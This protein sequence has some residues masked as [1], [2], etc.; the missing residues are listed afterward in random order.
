MSDTK[1][2]LQKI[3]ALR[4]R[5]GPIAAPPADAGG[6]RTDSAHAAL[7]KVEQGGL[8]NRLIDRALRPL[9]PA[10]QTA[11]LPVRLTA[12]GARMLVKGRDL[13]QALRAVADDPALEA[14]SLDPLAALHAGTVAMIDTVLRAV[15]AFPPSATEQLRLCE[16]L[17][18]ILAAVEER[19]GVLNA[20]LN[21][22]RREIGHIDY[23]AEILRR[24]AAGQPV[25]LPPLLALAETVVHEARSGRP[26]RFL[27]AAAGDPARFV[28]AHSLTVA[29]VLAR[30]LLQGADTGVPVQLAVTAA[31]VHDVGMLRVPAEILG[32]PGALTDEERRLIEKHAGAGGP[33]VAPLWPGGGWPV[34]AVT[35]HHERPDGTGYPFGR[36]DTQVAEIVRLLA[37]CDTYAALCCPRPHRPAMD[38]RT[39][40]TETLMLAERDAL[41]REQAERLLVLSFY[42]AGSVVELNDG[43]AAL[44]LSAQPGLRALASPSRPIVLLL[45]DAHLQALALPRVIDLVQEKERSIVRGLPSTDRRRL[46]GQRYPELV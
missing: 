35:D 40:L 46:L 10:I 13:L 32:K 37:V 36:K 15:Q 26:L 44:V 6:V 27:H 23:L 7:D 11:P 8:H 4:Q 1:E 33:M 20:G 24:L 34:D 38:S 43:A 25:T 12:S 45:T 9:D 39:A 21:H 2:L 42:P 5:L 22:R 18:A 29:Q 16:G 14:D 41:D 17:E 30:L 28:A 31:L 3:A 19:V